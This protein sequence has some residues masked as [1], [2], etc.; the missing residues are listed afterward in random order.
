[1]TCLSQVMVGPVFFDLFFPHKYG[2]TRSFTSWRSFLPYFM[3]KF[4][5]TDL[6][7]LYYRNNI[8]SFLVER[9]QLHGNREDRKKR[10]RK[11]GSHFVDS[12]YL[13]WPYGDLENLEYY[14]FCIILLQVRVRFEGIEAFG[15]EWFS[16]YYSV[17]STFC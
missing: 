16:L 9:Q 11:S 8:R 5:L 6:T 7:T 17:Y 2:F 14:L 3:V 1:M 15:F 4:S 12:Y 13:C 10:R